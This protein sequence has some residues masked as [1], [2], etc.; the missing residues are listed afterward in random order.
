MKMLI[1]SIKLKRIHNIHD[2]LKHK[3][4]KIYFNKN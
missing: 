2:I 3:L 4:K 1:K